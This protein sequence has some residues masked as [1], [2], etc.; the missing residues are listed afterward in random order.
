[1]A[2]PVYSPFGYVCVF[3]VFFSIKTSTAVLGD[4]VLQT[5]NTGRTKANSVFSIN[6][7]VNVDYRALKGLTQ[8]CKLTVDEDD[9]TKRDCF[10]RMCRCTNT[11]ADCSNNNGNLTFIPKLP[12]SIRFLNFSGNS[13][14]AIPEGFFANVS[15]LTSLSLNNN[16]IS[17]I[18]P[19][20]FK[21]LKKLRSLYINH[22]SNLTA[23]ALRSVFSIKSLECL[24]LRYNGLREL[25][26]DRLLGG[27]LPNLVALFLHD[28]YL[29]LVNLTV[30]Q[31]LP[32]L[33]VL[34]WGANDVYRFIPAEMQQ[35]QRID[36]F[37][38]RI[39]DF[40]QT[41]KTDLN[42]ASSELRFVS[43]RTNEANSPGESRFPQLKVLLLNKNK[44]DNLPA[45]IC[46]PELEYLDLS[47]NF[48][49][50]LPTDMFKPTLFPKI[51][52]LFLENLDTHVEHIQPYAF[53]HPELKFLS[54]MYNDIDFSIDTRYSDLSFAGCPKLQSLQL[55]HNYFTE[56]SDDRFTS[57]VGNVST[58]EFLY[59]GG[60][61]LQQVTTRTFSSLHK[62]RVL[63]L[64]QNKIP[65]IPDG[66][67]DSN[68]DLYELQLNENRITTV[69]PST[70]SQELK[71]NLTW[72]DLSGNPFIC[73]CDLRWFSDWLQSG[74]RA[75][76]HSW[77]MHYNCT[78]LDNSPVASFRMVEQACILH[79]SQSTA[80]IVV[81]S[82]ALVGVCLAMLV[83]HFRWRIRLKLYEVSRGHEHLRRHVLR[84]GKYVF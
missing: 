42:P 19:Q 29:E 30:F 31:Q 4:D 68:K 60:V 58:L 24:D 69:T 3:V 6:D 63:E 81:C 41:C 61:G 82:V 7:R 79:Y 11:T 47:G 25:P 32:K 78:N 17:Y 39:V 35:L 56:V 66:A 71:T 10:Y 40:P 51:H 64:Y 55:S 26:D 12:R 37:S 52:Y 57:L 67:F 76:S 83:W 74:D 27:V 44:I 75:F 14:G 77:S 1:M 49:P 22:N 73:D 8:T 50:R 80:V 21:S 28:N 59:L 5:I 20:A 62:L 72:L 53:R 65:A 46:L 33:G 45:K 13:L 38:N 9:K 84:T 23:A 16:S 48:F 34:S 15:G 43:Q 70:F 54:L 2:E 36:L 18:H